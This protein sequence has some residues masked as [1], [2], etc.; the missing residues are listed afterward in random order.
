MRTR[1]VDQQQ[2]GEISPRDSRDADAPVMAPKSWEEHAGL[3]QLPRRLPWRA[4][5]QF[6]DDLHPVGDDRQVVLTPKNIRF[7]LPQLEN[8]LSASYTSGQKIQQLAEPEPIDLFALA[9]AVYE[10]LP[11]VEFECPEAE[12]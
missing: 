5:G 4:F 12:A 10:L 6:A 3:Q 1:L 2:R 8:G 11:K 7:W 9:E